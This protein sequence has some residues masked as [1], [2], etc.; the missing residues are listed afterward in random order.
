MASIR[1]AEERVCTSVYYLSQTTRCERLA[2]DLTQRWLMEYTAPP[3]VPPLS[4][5]SPSP[6]PVMPPSPSMPVGFAFLVSYG[7]TLSTF[8]LPVALP[9]GGEMDTFGYYTSDLAA[10][11]TALAGTD[12]LVRACVPGAPLGCQSAN[13]PAQCL[14][15]GR[16][17]ADAVANAENPWAEIRFKVTGGSYLWGLKIT[18]PRNMQLSE[19]FVGT[20]TVQLWGV[21]DEPLPCAEGNDEV[22]GVPENWEITIVC[23]P[24]TA[25]DLQLHQLSGAYRARV[26]LTGSTR[27]VWFEN[28]QAIERPLSAITT[29]VRPAPSPPPPKP[30]APPG[31]PPPPGAVAPTV[32]VCTHH[33]NTWI[34]ASVSHRLVHEPCGQTGEACC[35]SM[36]ELAAQAYQIDDSGCCDLVYLDTGVLL[37]GVAVA[38]DTGRTGA[39]SARAGTGG[40]A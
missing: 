40:P 25:T 27:Q 24:P 23:H 26:T 37:T 5:V 3:L 16:R 36:H 17:C 1:Q 35:A 33:A 28:I 11:K 21:R 15:G 39:Y 2:V 30:G 6:P 9:V 14:N 18:L 19:Y 29:G 7:A 12:Q 8:R 4:L 22:V 13:I 38:V 20:K 31:T 32:P 10:V 34:D